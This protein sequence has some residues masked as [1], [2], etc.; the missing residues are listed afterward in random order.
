ME[1]T[2]D[3]I[4]EGYLEDKIVYLKPSP[5]SGKMI[6]SPSH[7]GYFMYEGATINFVL[8][9]NSRG[10]LVDPFKSR[11]EREF[12]EKELGVDL[13][14][15]KKTDNFWNTFRVKFL[16]NPIS[17]YD[18]EKFNLADPMDNLRVRV[19]RLSPDVAP[20]WEER[21]KSPV[22]RFALVEDDYEENKA[23][24][25]AQKL[26]EI[27]KYFG[28]VSNNWT[29]MYEFV[30]V[31]LA[32]K[33]AVATVPSDA[34]KEWLIKEMTHIIE[35]D[36]DGYLKIVKD[37]DFEIKAFILNAVSVG[38]IEK[39]G[40]NKYVIPGESTSWSL[41]DFVAYMTQL[42]EDSDDVYLKIKAQLNLKK[43]GKS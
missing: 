36:Q 26:Q 9:V 41:N 37:K 22:Y 1:V 29:K 28:S 21:F 6:K 17:M 2:V 25:E 35:N 7:V 32:T 18:G 39:T 42:K 31:Y 38:A 12:F 5:R 43:K 40:V 16:K 30:S 15:H 33:K 23:A 3:P 19:L 8:P 4:K 10:S 20:S 24:V 34:T 27:W 13:N 11:E 14:I